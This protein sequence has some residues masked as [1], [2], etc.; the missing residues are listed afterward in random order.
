MKLLPPLGYYMGNVKIENSTQN[1]IDSLKG[2]RSC[3]CV[4]VKSSG[5][6]GVD[7][8]I[9]HLLTSFFE[10]FDELYMTDVLSKRCKK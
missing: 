3:H 1:Y 7:F 10:V 4:F 9:I 8:N 6:S 5:K 2:F